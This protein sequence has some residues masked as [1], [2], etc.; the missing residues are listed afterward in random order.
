MFVVLANNK[1]GT[2]ALQNLF[3]HIIPLSD[4]LSFLISESFKTMDD[5]D[6]VLELTLNIHGNHVIQLCLDNLTQEEH[7]ERIYRTVICNCARIATDK[8][9]CCVI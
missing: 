6:K 3:K 1:H 8:H 4:R 9:G 2:R 7:K 5:S